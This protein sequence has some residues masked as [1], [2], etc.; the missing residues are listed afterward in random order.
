MTAPGAVTASA[1]SC[2]IW[3]GVPPPSPGAVANGLDG[4]RALGPCNVW[5]VGS[6][7]NGTYGQILSLAEHE[8]GT[9]WKVMPTPSPDTDR[10]VLS[11]VGAATIN[12]AWAVGQTGDKTFI[13]HWNGRFWTQAP[14]PSPSSNTNDL[15]G[16][17]VVSATDA[18]AVGQYFT[19]TTVNPLVLQWDGQQWTQK[20]VPAPGSGSVLEAVAATSAK[21]AWAVGAFNTSGGQEKTLIER[22]NGTKWVQV[23]SPNPA[24]P[25]GEIVLGGVV[26]TSAS[27]AWAVGTYSTGTTDKTL[28]EHWN[29]HAWTL[30]ASPNPA[31]RNSLLAVAAT[32]AGNVWAVGTRTTSTTQLT[33][34]VRWNG[35]K[36]VQVPSPSPGQQVNELAGVA[37]TSAT[38][39]WAVGDFTTGGV[40]QVLAAHCC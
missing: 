5:A 38:D 6:Y 17:A 18:W 32:S 28:I 20:A 14:S 23:P 15:S 10:N 34:I 13:L 7:Q 24:G 31:P 12:D 16:V 22:W 2:E 25:V 3:S 39:V 35:T 29:G 40:T 1:A 33:L 26:A 21:D 19:S 11:A 37:T 36:W 27:N 8:N 4:I 9:A 30:V